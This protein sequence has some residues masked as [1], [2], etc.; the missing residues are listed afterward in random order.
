MIRIQHFS[1]HSSHATDKFNLSRRPRMIAVLL[2]AVFGVA[3]AQASPAPV[4]TA[5]APAKPGNRNALFVSPMGEPFRGQP[6]RAAALEAW[7]VQ[8]DT[9]GNRSLSIAEM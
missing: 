4:Y 3:A 1:R 2:S 5:P 7:F 8:A 6:T 9:D